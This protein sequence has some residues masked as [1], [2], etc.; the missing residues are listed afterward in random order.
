MVIISP[1]IYYSLQ[2]KYEIDKTTN[3]ITLTKYQGDAEIVNI[4]DKIW[5]KEV[6][7]LKGTFAG[8]SVKKVTLP[9][10]INIIGE[11]AFSGCEQMENI[12]LSN[13]IEIIDKYAFI[14]CSMLKEINLPSSLTKIDESAFSYCESL[15]EII[16]PRNVTELGPFAFASC[17]SVKK[18]I[19]PSNVTK[20]GE[21]C[22]PGP[23]NENLEI[24]TPAGSAAE[25]FLIEHGYRYSTEGFE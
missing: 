14:A 24:Y 11:R 21:W 7:V 17:D 23:L 3:K 1:N 25:K 8:K 20:M 19:I 13:N 16:I 10:T 15:K 2:Y 22:L 6:A 12:I 5:W 4:P 9:D 18:L